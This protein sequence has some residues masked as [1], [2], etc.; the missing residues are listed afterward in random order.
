MSVRKRCKQLG[1][2]RVAE[3]SVARW[4]RSGFSCF[5]FVVAL[6]LRFMPH[7]THCRVG[8]AAQQVF[9]GALVQ[10]LWQLK[11]GRGAQTPQEVA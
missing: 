4:T 2:R 8:F 3:T 10:Q 11:A 5:S 6:Q 1:K 9:V 7:S